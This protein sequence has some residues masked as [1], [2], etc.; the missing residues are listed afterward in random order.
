ML[1][2]TEDAEPLEII[3]WLFDEFAHTDTSYNSLTRRLNERKVPA[4]GGGLQGRQAV[5][6]WSTGQVSRILTN[7]AYVGDYRYG[8]RAVGTYYR[9]LG[10]KPDGTDEITQTG[11]GAGRQCNA[12]PMLVS[13][14]HTGLIDRATLGHRPSEGGGPEDAKAEAAGQRNGAGRRPNPLRP[15]RQP[16][17]RRKPQD[18]RG[19]VYNYYVCSGNKEQ[20]GD[21]RVLQGTGGPAARRPTTK[22]TD[23]YLAPERLEGLRQA[24]RLRVEAKKEEDPVRAER[25]R[26]KIADM[27]R[28]I[29]Q[30]AKNLI[31]D[32]QSGL[33]SGGVDG[34]TGRPRAGR[35]GI[36][37][38]R[39][40]QR[41]VPG[42]SG[43]AR[44]RGGGTSGGLA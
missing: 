26:R 21:V 12:S 36:G 10:P 33:G 2:P 20:A 29:K 32:G 23:E 6:E 34:L 43:V 19:R 5:T 27:D 22:L 7:P 37:G 1:T 39:A 16:D 13:E 40:G 35:Q 18:A 38:G 15:L 14:N 28:D 42:R 44:G 25:L 41:R 31:R 4:P 8:L 17:V 11:F 24:L 9:Y 30:G 3:R